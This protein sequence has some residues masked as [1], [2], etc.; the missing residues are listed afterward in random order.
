M[1]ARFA[2]LAIGTAVVATMATTA[3]ALDF[4][5]YFRSG[6]GFDSKGGGQACFQLPGTDFKSRLGNECDNYLEIGFGQTLWKD[7]S[8]VEFYYQFMPGWGL[9]TNSSSTTIP[10]TGGPVPYG[11]G[12]GSLYVQQNWGSVK[13]PGLGTVWAGWRYFQRHNIDNLDWFWWN[14]AQGNGAAGIEDVNLGF[15]KLA[16]TIIRLETSAAAGAISTAPTFDLRLSNIGLWENGSLELGIDLAIYNGH[17]GLDVP[18]ASPWFTA[19][20]NQ[21]KV[22]GGDNFLGFQYASGSIYQMGGGVVYPPSGGGAGSRVGTSD[23]SQW[24]VLDQ[25]VYHPVP[26]FSGELAVVYQDKVQ[27][28]LNEVGIF[29]LQ[30]RPA[31]HLSEYF[32]IAADIAYQTVDIKK[33]TDAAGNPIT[34]T[35]GSPHL[36]KLTLAPTLVAG[37]KNG[38]W[39][40]P[41]I[42]FFATYASWGNLYPGT[43]IANGV[44]G[45]DKNGLSFGVQAEAWW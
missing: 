10:P 43:T 32:K 34:V 44:F 7:D 26:E 24:R 16:F 6:V 8:G 23:S 35:T 12:T 40:R 30:V 9:S 22:W 17:Y 19:I 31:Y 13:L 20:L 42:R 25:F 11:Y 21:A 15:A 14:P 2:A 3:S 37:Q 28:K 33:V 18:T 41:E 29:T 4:T 45:T 1:K 5:G 27:D 36:L 38:L 39:A